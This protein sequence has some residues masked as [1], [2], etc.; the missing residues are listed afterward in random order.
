MK[1]WNPFSHWRHKSYGD[2]TVWMTPAQGEDAPARRSWLQELDRLAVTT[3]KAIPSTE[4]A[5]LNQ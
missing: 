4:A 3:I 1:N 2:L 5:E